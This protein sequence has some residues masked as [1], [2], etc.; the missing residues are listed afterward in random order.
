M[1]SSEI[2]PSLNLASYVLRNIILKK[3]NSMIMLLTSRVVE[4]VEMSMLSIRP[5]VSMT[6]FG[7]LRYSKDKFV[8]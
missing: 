1:I 7:S 8:S 5:I 2:S 3:L 6:Q 4:L